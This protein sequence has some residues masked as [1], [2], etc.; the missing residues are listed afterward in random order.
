MIKI[1]EI[2][3]KSPSGSLWGI[4]VSDDGVLTVTAK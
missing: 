3:L 1:S 2:I 4:T